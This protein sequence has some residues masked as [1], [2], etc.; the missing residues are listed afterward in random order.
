MVNSKNKNEYEI[1]K[2]IFIS[3]FLI[4]IYFDL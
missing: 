4:K 3:Y 1:M 2:Q